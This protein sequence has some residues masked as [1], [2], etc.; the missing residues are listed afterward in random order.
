MKKIICLFM[1][2]IF[3]LSLCSCADTES[4]I[5]EK[6]EL[7]KK[8][9][10]YIDAVYDVMSEW[11]N[12]HRDGSD[13]YHINKIAFLDFDGTGN[14]VFYKNY[15]LLA[16]CGS[17]Y[18]VKSDGLYYIDPDIYDQDANIR[19]KSCLMR[20]SLSGTEWD[21]SATKKEKYKI[22]ESAYKEFIKSNTDTDT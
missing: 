7:T 5:P 9:Y 2:A 20:T 4:Q 13:I 12:T 6:I 16:Y 15:P 21:Y 18:Y 1:F 22:I 11:D 10:K 8:D 3:C 19:H 17:G 14:I